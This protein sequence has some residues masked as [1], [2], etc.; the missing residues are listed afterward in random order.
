M[1]MMKAS[2]GGFSVWHLLLYPFCK[3]KYIVLKPYL[4]YKVVYKFGRFISVQFRVY[5]TYSLLP[6]SIYP[7]I[8]RRSALFIFR[9]YSSLLR[10]IVGR[11]FLAVALKCLLDFW[12][13]LPPLYHLASLL[14]CCP[15]SFISDAI[16]FSSANISLFCSFVQ[17]LDACYIVIG[18]IPHLV[19]QD[20]L[21]DSE[22]QANDC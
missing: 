11:S 18:H 2:F 16:V 13:L 1:G 20:Y 9:R 19:E 12:L 6:R 4:F 3:L 17:R 8:L 15:G 14:L 7:R 22:N 21:Q 5:S 10:S